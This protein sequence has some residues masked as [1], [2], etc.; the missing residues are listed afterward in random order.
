MNIGPYE[1][2]R[3]VRLPGATASCATRDEARYVLWNYDSPVDSHRQSTLKNAYS[4]L[5]EGANITVPRWHKEKGTLYAVEKCRDEELLELPLTAV[6][7]LSPGHQR[8]LLLSAVSAV[9]T[10]ERHGLVHGN[11]NREAFRICRS[12]DNSLSF[13]LVGLGA[14][15]MAGGFEPLRIG[16]G[17][18]A[19]PE[20]SAARAVSSAED[21]FSLGVC[22][23]V[24]LTGNLPVLGKATERQFM[25]VS[26]RVPKALVP[27]VGT[28]LSPKP[29]QR[30]SATALQKILEG[31]LK[32]RTT[33]KYKL[34]Y[35]GASDRD[36]AELVEEAILDQ[37]E[38]FVPFFQD[39]DARSM[40]WQ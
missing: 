9:A 18:Y 3:Q 1:I 8:R 6:S 7:Q 32:M 37:H 22:F 12:Q 29:E 2:Q 30:P 27:I 36:G 13:Q 16:N 33:H 25:L 10:L 17:D 19:A 28:M 21:V 35:E 40:G 15:G 38:Q 23:H 26:D 39:R 11:L 5:I 34:W 31:V 20:T 14:A 4:G 24:W